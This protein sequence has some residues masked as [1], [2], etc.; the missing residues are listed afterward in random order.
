MEERIGVI[1]KI[2]LKDYQEFLASIVGPTT[3]VSPNT[4]VS[5]N[6]GVNVCP[7][8]NVSKDKTEVKPIPKNAHPLMMNKINKYR[9]DL[10]KNNMKKQQAAFVSHGT[11]DD[12]EKELGLK[13]IH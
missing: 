5:P 9:K 3:G 10:E 4:N 6:T 1:Q 8:T 11:I 7:T 2:F 12:Y 13:P